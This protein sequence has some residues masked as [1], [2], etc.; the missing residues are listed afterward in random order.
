MHNLST[1]IPSNRRLVVAAVASGVIQLILLGVSV[2]LAS[3]P[4]CQFEQCLGLSFVLGLILLPAAIALIPLLIL[5]AMLKRTP[6]L[7]TLWVEGYYVLGAALS[8]SGSVAIQ[9]GLALSF[10]ASGVCSGVVIVS[11]IQTKA[12]FDVTD[13][14][15][16]E[17]A[18]RSRFGLLIGGRSTDGR[19]VGVDRGSLADAAGIRVGDLIT[20]V[21]GEAITS[22]VRLIFLLKTKPQGDAP[23]ELTLRDPDGAIRAVLLEPR[24]RRT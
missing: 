15:R 21:N 9:F 11:L 23:S 7:L 4:E 16:P 5:T 17:S 6:L 19:I 24:V 18:L 3:G 22:R 10:L 2:L 20:H 14:E 13:A 12:L 1:W 8:G